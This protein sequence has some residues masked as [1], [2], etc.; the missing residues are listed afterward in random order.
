A[1]SIHDG[2]AIEIRARRAETLAAAYAAN[3]DRFRRKPAPPKLPEA[4]WI[5]EP[6]KENTDTEHAA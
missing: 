2:T 4:A 6:P 3:P 5:N 1:A